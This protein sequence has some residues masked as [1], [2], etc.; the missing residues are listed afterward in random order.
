[1]VVQ[2][3]NRQFGC[4]TIHPTKKFNSMI[5]LQMT[6]L[7]TWAWLILTSMEAVRCQAPYSDRTLWHL[8]STFGWSHSASSAYQRFTK[9]QKISYDSQPSFS[10]HI[11]N[12]TL[13]MIIGKS[14]VFF[15]TCIC[16]KLCSK[17]LIKELHRIKLL[18][19]EI[20]D[21]AGR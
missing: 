20:I 5:L 21:N 3:C 14:F 9:K 10:L 17:S 16:Y 18:H 4:E 1:M 2:S 13:L 12:S 8:S 11:S 15:S 6:C 7:I 19:M